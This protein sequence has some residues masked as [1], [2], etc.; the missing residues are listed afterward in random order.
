M[1][2]IIY[3]GNNKIFLQA[4]SL[5]IPSGIYNV[6]TGK[7]VKVYKIFSI[8]EN[9]ANKLINTVKSNIFK[10]QNNKINYIDF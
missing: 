3:I 2:M 1:E 7:S 10:D 8:V 5:N 4:M 6:G 9:S